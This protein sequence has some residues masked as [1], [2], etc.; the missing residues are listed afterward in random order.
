MASKL[1]SSVVSAFKMHGY[2][3]RSDASKYLV[4]ILLPVSEVSREDWIDRILEAVEKQSLTSSVVDKGIVQAAV[5]ECKTEGEDNSEEVMTIIDAFSVPK[6]T[7]LPDRKKFLPNL[8]CNKMAPN[9]HSTA[10]DKADIFRDRYQILHQRTCRHDLFTPLMLGAT[11]E[12][13][14]R[15]FQLKPIE[16]LLGCT[17]KIGEVIVL[18]MLTQ[19]KEGKLYLED[20]TGAVQLDLSTTSFHQGLFTENSF[21]LAEGWY[22]DSIFH[23]NAL[24]FPPAEPA[25]TTRAY[26]G[27]VN[28]FGGPSKTSVKAS[29]RLKLM[30]EQNNG[31]MFVFLSDVWLDQAKVMEKLNVLFKGYSPIPPTAFILCGNFCSEPYGPSYTKTL[32][33]SF[34]QLADMLLQFPELLE[35]S[36]FVFVPGPLDPGPGKILPRP[37]LPAAITGEFERRVPQATFT[38]N[39]CRV[40]YCTQEIVVF[41]ENAVAKTCRNCVR[42]PSA[43][44]VAQ[45]F[46][47]TIIAQGHLCPLPL[48]LSPVYWSHDAALRLYPLPDV[49]VC[50]DAYDPYSETLSDCLVF[51]PGSFPKSGFSFKVYMPATKAVEVSRVRDMPTDTADSIDAMQGAG[52]SAV[53]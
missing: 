53:W 34:A 20:P 21:V 19:V 7:Y 25:R 51:N 4:D 48:H 29:A 11:A 6:F 35:S 44:G 33:K 40:Q 43:A 50:A 16:Y 31:A 45:H 32:K 27:D 8:S 47:R 23:V 39:P 17:A 42:L 2:C 49:V 9:L 12:E 22:E 5:H 13:S 36:K 52:D 37:R 3:L 15:K 14:A 41:R 1:K 26:F 30:E 38:S 28:F 24:G 46:V 18:G 10:K